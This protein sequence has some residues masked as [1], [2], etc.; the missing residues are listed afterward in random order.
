MENKTWYGY[1]MFPI[2]YGWHW[3]RTVREFVASLSPDYDTLYPEH[4]PD[5]INTAVGELTQFS[6]DMKQAMAIA[7]ALGWEGDV[8]GDMHVFPIP[9]DTSFTYGFAWKHDNNG[10]TF[11]ISPVPLPHLIPYTFNRTG[12]L[13]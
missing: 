6:C 9:S 13:A 3:C 11:I 2:D 12:E 4:F 8:R 10:D 5:E 7:K 1:G